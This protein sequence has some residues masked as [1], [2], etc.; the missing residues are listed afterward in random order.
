MQ[1]SALSGI[2]P[3]KENHVL[4]SINERKEGILKKLSPSICPQLINT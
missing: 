3:W 1:K 4:F 2:H